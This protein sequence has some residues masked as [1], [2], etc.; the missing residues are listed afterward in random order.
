MGCSM[1]HQKLQMLNCCTER[2]KAR[3]A[4]LAEPRGDSCMHTDSPYKSFNKITRLDS[5]TNQI[6]RDRVDSSTSD[7]GEFS[8]SSDDEFYECMDDDAS[9]KSRKY[10][11]EKAKNKT[12]SLDR[13]ET[14]D[15][16]GMDECA[17]ESD[18]VDSNMSASQ[19]ESV[20]AS[21]SQSDYPAATGSQSDSSRVSSSFQSRVK[22]LESES[23]L[24]FT[25]SYTHQPDGRSRPYE[26]LHLLNMDEVMY[27]PLTQEPAPMTEDMLE[28]HAEVLAK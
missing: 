18:W 14:C 17:M 25:D 22:S 3:E 2:K 15:S 16:S 13:G 28:E 21:G 10:F 27:I 23:E 19:S 7:R 26:D 4:M 5:V 20:I 8:T 12:R 6:T 24:S 11:H 9:S 1:L